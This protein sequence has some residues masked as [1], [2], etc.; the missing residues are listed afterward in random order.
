M[1]ASVIDDGVTV[2]GGKA[3]QVVGVSGGI[4]RVDLASLQEMDAE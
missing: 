3:R 4:G 1:V 2:V